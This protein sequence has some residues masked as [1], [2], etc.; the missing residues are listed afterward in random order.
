MTRA[1]SWNDLE[2]TQAIKDVVAKRIPSWKDGLRPFQE[3]PIIHILKG[4][5]V[6]LCNAT[7]DGKPALFTVPILC[8]LEISDFPEA[9]PSLPAKSRP[10]GLIV[11][12]TKELA[13][14]IVT[15]LS[16]Y[17]IVTLSYCH[18]TLTAARKSGRNLTKEIAACKMYQVI[19]VDPEHILGSE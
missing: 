13:G 4:K 3:Q 8:H 12:P 19:C 9:Y 1:L 10:V 2:G 6:L 16:E 15:Q 5:D 11:T 17:G 14:N 7:G 18:E